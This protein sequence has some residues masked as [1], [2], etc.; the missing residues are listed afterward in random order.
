MKDFHWPW[1]KLHS[2][3]FITKRWWLQYKLGLVHFIGF[4]IRLILMILNIKTCKPTTTNNNSYKG[5]FG[6]NNF[7]LI[8]WLF[9]FVRYNGPRVTARL[10]PIRMSYCHLP[11]FKSEHL[12]QSRL[13]PQSPLRCCQSAAARCE[14][15]LCGR[16]SPSI[17]RG[18]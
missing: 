11:L 17:H 18:C 7:H 15:C 9:P 8:M 14:L 12:G 4:G 13:S 16:M 10:Q 2:F 1:G 6:V 3:S 5:I